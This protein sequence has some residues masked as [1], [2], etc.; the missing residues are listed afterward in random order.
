MGLPMNEYDWRILGEGDPV[1][2]TGPQQTSSLVRIPVHGALTKDDKPVRQ[3][4]MHVV[5]ASQVQ[6]VVSHQVD[7]GAGLQSISIGIYT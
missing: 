4:I 6:V 3:K 5:D 7:A 1:L 2:P